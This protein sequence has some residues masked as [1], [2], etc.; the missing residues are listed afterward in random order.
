MSKYQW[1]SVRNTPKEDEIVLVINENVDM[2]PIKAYWNEETKE[3][4]S[5][6]TMYL[7]PIAVTHWIKMPKFEKTSI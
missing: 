7:M 5:V 6:D 3:F 2:L 1:H 4:L